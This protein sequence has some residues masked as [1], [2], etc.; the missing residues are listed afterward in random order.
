MKRK[1]ISLLV[2]LCLALG[3]FTIPASAAFNDISDPDVAV[4]AAVLQ[5]MGIVTGM[6]EN[7]YSPGTLLTRAQFCT[8]AVRAMGLEDKA[9][10]HAYKT[11]F[12]DVKPG[13]WYTGY[14]NLAYAEGII[15]GYGNGKFGPDDGINYGQAATLLLRMLGYTAEEVGNVWPT[16][17]IS[18]ANDLGLADSV[19]VSDSVSRGQAA[20]L[21][22]NTMKTEKN[23]V[24]TPYYRTIN[25]VAS[26]ETAIIL[27]NDASNGG[28]N[29][30]LMAGRITATGVS[31]EYYSQK[32][33]ASDVL[34]GGIGT[35]LLNS[36]GKAVGFIPDSTKF[37][38]ITISSASA[39]AVTASTKES[40]RIG[41]GATLIYNG[42]L[43]N[44]SASGYIQVN[45]QAGKNARL[46]YD[47]N[48][49]VKYIY[50]ISGASEGT[51]SAV[52]E[53]NSA[54]S[55]L[56]RKLGITG[57]G[58]SIT[59]NGSAASEGDLAQYDVA[60]YNRAAKIMHVSDY[61]V[62]GYISGAY[63]N[64][65][66][67]ESLTVSGCELAVLE[68]AWDTLRSFSLGDRVILLLTDDNKVAAAYSSGMS[69]KMTGIL[70]DKGDSVTLIDS[71]LI[72]T[73]ND[74]SAPEKLRGSLVEVSASSKTALSCREPSSVSARVD[75]SAGTVG[76]Y[77]LAPA[78]DI[79][80]WA[81]NGYVYSLAGDKGLSSKDFKEVFW[82]T[83]LNS[84]YVSWYRVNSAG[85]VDALL[86]NNATGNCYEYG[87]IS[88][89]TGRE[90]I[91][92]G[93]M[94]ESY[95]DAATITNSANPNGSAKYLCLS[96][97]NG[98]GGLS[99]SVYNN[100]YRDAKPISLSGGVK[101]GK[102]DFFQ[103]G[104]DWYVTA[105]GYEIPVSEK[106]QVHVEAVGKWYGGEE[107]L[108]TA[109]S[110]GMTITVYYDKTPDTG[111]QIRIV[112]V[113][114]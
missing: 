101:A 33:V 19:V 52:A 54:A 24:S 28:T 82:T 67:A 93:T 13:N 98:Y 23:G 3:V 97:T 30:L 76:E 87:K 95:N 9:S 15:N 27:S 77:K 58:Y 5:G 7:T 11:L 29:G 70:S 35:L 46:Y 57:A 73:A 75:I 110:S 113:T 62:S 36:A 45:S 71:G 21:L 85:Q 109:L 38:D 14:V 89:Y 64:V 80:E 61:R 107:G 44:Y 31:I 43:Y 26:A 99:Y 90:G 102:S 86:L 48:D 2:A 53:T 94:M 100:A 65:E 66:A 47:D 17:Y 39:S 18:F 111:A 1:I 49:A 4:A 37:T 78:C 69:D 112:S 12:T 55:E 10:S 60:Y 50:I 59:K 34:E 96:A 83:S 56:A 25:G 81:G 8:L 51:D 88:A 63:P 104:D 32:Y 22:Y 79:Y 74:I 103:N 40:F 41:S 42:S 108:M 92:L 72:L 114:A 91:N 84:S 16:D 106:V 6:S 68:S 20:M 105:G